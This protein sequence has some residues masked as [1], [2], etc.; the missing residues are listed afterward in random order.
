MNFIF[1]LVIPLLMMFMIYVAPVQSKT[2]YYVFSVDFDKIDKVE[3]TF[4]EKSLELYV[5]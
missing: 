3:S 1:A 5:P 2:Y 4:M